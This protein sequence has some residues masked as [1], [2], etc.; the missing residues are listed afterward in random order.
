MGDNPY[1]RMQKI[2][3]GGACKMCDRPYTM[4][5]WRPGRGEG[6]RKTEVCLT[7]SK[8]KNICQT[9]IL[10]LQFG[11]PS[12]LRD[13]VLA[14]TDQIISSESDANK[15]FQVQKQLKLL[16]N[17]ENPWQLANGSGLTPNEALVNVAR[18]ALTDRSHH[19][20]HI[21]P[22]EA[23]N[24]KR[25]HDVAFDVNVV[26]SEVLSTSS[27]SKNSQFAL[28]L[29]PGINSM[30][31]LQQISLGRQQDMKQAV[32]VTVTVDGNEKGDKKIKKNKKENKK[33]KGEN[34]FAPPKPPTGPPP[35]WAF[36][37][38]SDIIINNKD[39]QDK[40]QPV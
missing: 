25:Q 34:N 4:F 35:D 20:V 19:R 5:K 27:S 16:E 13:A 6:Y 7:C 3:Y 37:N 24:T 31:E 10:D 17:G 28:P 30:E 26:A 29:P 22:I 9:C 11:L 39:V 23:I 21:K 8:L 18:S 33:I 15:E 14:E 36:K 12:Q 2:D 32:T 40:Q 38:K 1:L